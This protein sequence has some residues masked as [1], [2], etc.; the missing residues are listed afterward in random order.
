[1]TNQSSGKIRH[2]LS[3][4]DDGLLSITGF[5]LLFLTLMIFTDVALRFIFNAP[6]PASAEMSELIMPYI[7]FCA[8]AYTL[9]KGSHI[10]I[11]LFIE[12]ASASVRMTLDIICCVFGLLCCAAF[13]Y[14]SW[15]LFWQSVIINEEM[16]AIIKLPWWVGKFSMPL[17]FFFFTMRYLLNLID[18]CSGKVV[19]Q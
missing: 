4:V 16:I 1:M 3:L 6:L 10:R 7:A 19:K 11:T 8:L 18:I 17:G 15:L 13:T 5:A 9:F 14:Y 12:H 2:A